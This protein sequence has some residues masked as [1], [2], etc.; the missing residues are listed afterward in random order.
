MWDFHRIIMTRFRHR[1][2]DAELP[3][4]H[5][6]NSFQRGNKPSFSGKLNW[7]PQQR[8]SKLRPKI[9]L[10]RGASALG[11]ASHERS[12]GLFRREVN[13][14]GI[15][16][17][18]DPTGSVRTVRGQR[19]QTCHSESKRAAPL[20]PNLS[21]VVDHLSWNCNRCGSTAS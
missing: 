19:F 7:L 4:E 21:R 13:V 15:P 5:W 1:A 8:E 10:C 16:V 18:F 2:I 12:A 14:F 11:E 20:L 3:P 17:A 6:K 9:S